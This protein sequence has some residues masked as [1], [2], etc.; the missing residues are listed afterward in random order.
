MRATRLIPTLLNSNGPSTA[1]P[2]FVVTNTTPGKVLGRLT[3]GC[4]RNPSESAFTRSVTES[5]RDPAALEFAGFLSEFP[6]LQ[7]G[8][9][10]L[11]REN[12]RFDVRSRGKRA[13]PRVRPGT[14]V[15]V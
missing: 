15:E 4:C 9:D 8:V 11:H 7:R 3:T 14:M 10:D 1:P 2:H 6:I 13:T 5:L 12:A